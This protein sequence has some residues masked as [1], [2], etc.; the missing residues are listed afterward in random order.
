MIKALVIITV[1]SESLSMKYTFTDRYILK[2]FLA[3]VDVSIVREQENTVIIWDWNTHIRY[4]LTKEGTLVRQDVF[5]P[6]DI[7]ITEG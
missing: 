5:I 2:E 3:R 4:Q 6:E 7:E 1:L